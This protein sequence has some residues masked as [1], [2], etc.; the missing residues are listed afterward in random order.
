MQDT[1]P[2]FPAHTL[3]SRCFGSMGLLT[4][5]RGRCKMTIA[6]HPSGLRRYGVVNCSLPLCLNFFR[7]AVR[8]WKTNQPFCV[9]GLRRVSFGTPQKR[10][11]GRQGYPPWNPNFTGA[12]N[13]RGVL[14]C[15]TRT[16]KRRILCPA[17]RSCGAKRRSV[18]LLRSALGCKVL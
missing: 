8:Q 15:G 17:R 3:P 18:L 4:V 1:L 16:L 5:R 13:E 10:R 12:R 11:K 6:T 14:L 9:S 7:A 2:G